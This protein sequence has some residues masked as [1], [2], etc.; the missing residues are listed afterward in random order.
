MN[1]GV[2]KGPEF[3]YFGPMLF[4]IKVV[5]KGGTEIPSETK[6]PR[7]ASFHWK[8]LKPGE[9]F[10]IESEKS[11]RLLSDPVIPDGRR[12]RMG[13]WL[14]LFVSARKLLSLALLLSGPANGGNCV[15]GH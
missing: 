9:V 10:E 7:L 14:V 15:E 6:N 5:L 3:L 12:I 4:R 1:G 8:A 2:D 11:F 13:S